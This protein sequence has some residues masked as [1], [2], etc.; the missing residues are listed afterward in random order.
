MEKTLLIVKPG[1]V[2]RGLV[3]EI[4]SRLEKRGLKLVAMKMA[5]LNPEILKIHYAHLAGRPFY[6]L[7]EKSMMA[8]PVVLTAWEGA[9]A[10]SVVRAMAGTTDGSKA[11]PGT[12]RGDFCLSNQENVVHTSDSVENAKEELDRFFKPEDYFD[13]PS[14]LLYSIYS[15]DEL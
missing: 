2:Q 13:Y 6:P 10:V 1:A 5:Q 14:P 7:M 11:A 9:N 8:A 15:E 4:I 12:I 3:G